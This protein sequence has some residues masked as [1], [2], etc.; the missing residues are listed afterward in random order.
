MRKVNNYSSDLRVIDQDFN[1]DQPM[2]DNYLTTTTVNKK[3]Q[4]EQKP[5]RNSI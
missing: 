5:N 4:S 2:E 3:A 1:L